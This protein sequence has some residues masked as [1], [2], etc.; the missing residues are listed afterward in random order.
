[1]KSFFPTDGETHFDS[2]LFAREEMA[3]KNV[4]I[5]IVE[6][7][8]AIEFSKIIEIFFLLLNY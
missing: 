4:I 1:M 8:Y 6:D 2:H 5:R 3:I 7:T